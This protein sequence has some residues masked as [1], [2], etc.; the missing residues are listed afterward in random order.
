MCNSKNEERVKPDETPLLSE[1]NTEHD[2]NELVENK[3]ENDLNQSN[4][5]LI[6]IDAICNWV[7]RNRVVT[8]FEIGKSSSR[9]FLSF[10]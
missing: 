2:T 3:L 1:G 7:K 5:N 8:D 10:G 4:A 9:V 6:H